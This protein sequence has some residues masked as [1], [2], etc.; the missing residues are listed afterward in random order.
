MPGGVSTVGPPIAAEVLKL[1]AERS[2][3]LHV[4]EL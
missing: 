2:L 3:K 1:S 4:G